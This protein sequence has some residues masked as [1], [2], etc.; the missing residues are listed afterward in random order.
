MR[1]IYL[2][3]KALISLLVQIFNPSGGALHYICPILHGF[4][5]AVTNDQISWAWPLQ[6]WSRYTS[7]DPGGVTIQETYRGGAIELA[8]TNH[9]FSQ[10]LCS[11]CVWRVIIPA[12]AEVTRDLSSKFEFCML[13]LSHPN[14]NLMFNVDI[15]PCQFTLA[16]HLVIS[17]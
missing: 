5:T 13:G 8:K 7:L 1:V 2:R 3:S 6:V 4:L 10:W 9:A 17:G 11:K 12:K 16:L 14:L 15:R